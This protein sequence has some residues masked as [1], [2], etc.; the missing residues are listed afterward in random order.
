MFSATMPAEVAYWKTIH[1][2]PVEVTVGAKN[3]GSATYLTN[4]T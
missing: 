3:S 2:D 1:E 4:F